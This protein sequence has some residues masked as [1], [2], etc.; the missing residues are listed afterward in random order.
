MNWKNWIDVSLAWHPLTPDQSSATKSLDLSLIFGVAPVELPGCCKALLGLRGAG[1]LLTPR[2]GFLTPGSLRPNLGG[3]GGR[4]KSG[5][6][7]CEVTTHKIPGAIEWRLRRRVDYRSTVNDAL[8]ALST[9]A[10]NLMLREPCIADVLP[11][12]AACVVDASVFLRQG[13]ISVLDIA[14]SASFADRIID[15]GRRFLLN[16]ALGNF[17]AAR[18]PTSVAAHALAWDERRSTEVSGSSGIELEHLA[19]RFDPIARNLI[20][21]PAKASVQDLLRR[22]GLHPDTGLEG[23]CVPALKFRAQPLQELVLSGLH[24]LHADLSFAD[25]RGA[26]LRGAQLPDA[27]LRY[28]DLREAMLDDAR[29]PGADLTGA[30]IAAASLRRA[31]LRCTNFTYADLS[32][33]DL[34]DADLSGARLD[35]TCLIG[36]RLPAAVRPTVVTSR[37]RAPWAAVPGDNVAAETRLTVSSAQTDAHSRRRD[38]HVDTGSIGSTRGTAMD[39]RRSDTHSAAAKSNDKSGKGP[40]HRLTSA[41]RRHLNALLVEVDRLAREAA[42]LDTPAAVCD[43]TPSPRS[44]PAPGGQDS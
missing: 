30:R 25:M 34:S 19:E 39:A 4:A 38:S 28:A 22:V 11:D 18:F 13:D 31:D 1:L 3:G 10:L 33:A 27:N 16:V 14:W 35:G 42:E 26:K 8:C 43:A 5:C 37:C 21:A 41:A 17:L 12:S 9:G 2:N 44:K 23:L 20:N 36:T 24:A 6:I 29:L 32:R 15:P 7:I 40:A